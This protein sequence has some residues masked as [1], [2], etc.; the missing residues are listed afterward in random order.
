MRNEAFRG[1]TET[2]YTYDGGGRTRAVERG[3]SGE[4]QTLWSYDEQGRRA[5]EIMVDG[6]DI[7]T[8]TFHDDRN[9]LVR[10]D[11]QAAGSERVTTQH[12]RHYGNAGV[13]RE[14]S[15]VRWS[16]GGWVV[17]VQHALHYDDDGGFVY[18]LHTRSPLEGPRV[19]EGI[20]IDVDAHCRVIARRVDA[21]VDGTFDQVALFDFDNAGRLATATQ[22]KGTAIDTVARH[23]Y[24]DDGH[25]VRTTVEDAGGQP[26]SPTDYDFSC[27]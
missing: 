18:E 14:R 9:L 20:T 1:V 24:D 5:K 13:L 17:V 3:P 8:R 4:R 11:V 7:T 12:R 25:L 23:G 27:W 2:V 6:A 21:G 16:Q 10:E 15:E 22:M 26:L 19:V